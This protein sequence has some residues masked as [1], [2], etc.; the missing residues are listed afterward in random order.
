MVALVEPES[1]SES[2]AS[3]WRNPS[4]W[5]R[6]QKLS[7]GFWVFFTA[8]FFFDAGFAVYVFLF[9][10]YLL[11]HSF[12]DRSI[13]LI[14]GAMTLG[15]LVGTLPAGIVARRIGVKPVLVVCFVSASVLN[16]A[17]VVWVWEPAQ[18]GDRKSVV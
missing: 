1:S 13:G 12:S 5:I 18:L 10:L 11:D 2:V 15:T 16:A 6:Q 17:R 8:A 9:N 14:G 3:F 7:R 4:A